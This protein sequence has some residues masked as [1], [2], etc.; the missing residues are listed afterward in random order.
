MQWLT[1]TLT[2]WFGAGL[3]SPV[4]AFVRVTVIVVLA[5]LA[6]VAAG[7]LIRLLKSR[8]TTGIGDPAQVR[9]LETVARALRYVATAVIILIAGLLVL[10]ELGVS[11]APILGAAGIVGLAVG[12]GAQSLVKDY[13]SGFFLL[14]ENQIARGDVVRIA[15]RAGQVEDITLRYVRLR[16]YSGN[17]HYVPNGLITTVTNMSR[18]YAYAVMDIGVAYREDLGQVFEAI[19]ET[20]RALQE[21]VE[22][23]G[24]ILEPLEI[25]GVEELGDSAVVVRCRIK[26]QV[27]EQWNVR[28][29][30]LRLIKAAFDARGIEIPYPHLTLYAGADREGRAPAFPVARRE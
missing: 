20:G 2:S 23:A 28:R 30:F 26:V 27:L 22:F 13:F 17:V 11:I 8:I 19:R 21:D 9:R 5:V 12:F 24:R 18:D 3:A 16:D 29:E 7:R 6:K 4:M 14:L 1:E 15:D 25:A 10:S